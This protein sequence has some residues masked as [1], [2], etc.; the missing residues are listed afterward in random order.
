MAS[1]SGQQS[2][3]LDILEA[4]E[5]KPYQYSLFD[6]LRYL[7]S[8]NSDLPRLGE[9]LKVS[10]DPVYIRQ[11]PSMAFA[12]STISRF[13]VGHKKQSEIYNFPYGVF[14]ANGPLPLHLTEYA[15][16]R[17][18]QD[19][20]DT[21]S[22]FADIF[23]HRM[24]SLLY[25]SW[26]NTQPT[27]GFD[28]PDDNV[29]DKYVSA[30]AGN[31][32]VDEDLT[33][34]SKHHELF[35]AGLF[36]HQTR[37]ADGLETLLSDYFQ[38]GF[39]VAQYSGG[40]LPLREK[41]QFRLGS[42]GYSN[43]LGE[44]TCLGDKVYDCQHKFTIYSEAMD[45]EQFERLLPNTQSYN[46]LYEL[47]TDFVGVAFEWDLVFRIK[48]ANVPGW[49]LGQQGHLG[50]TNWLGAEESKTNMNAADKASDVVEISLL[51]RSSAHY[52]LS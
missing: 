27:I 30:I 50:W 4:I 1:K 2:S 22:R 36:S 32:I 31:S 40:W 38:V 14:G 49:T 16:E 35:R 20:D 18:I 44:N 45:F 10:D 46:K 29:F 52:G 7:E 26:A 47:V 13:D 23:H 15:Y 19:G 8:V 39:T 51:S 12:P 11:Q 25:R 28:R 43:S 48:R 37:S 33:H 9:S 17:E 24:V 3:S 42:Y 6:V 21:F 41:D 5:E 34:E